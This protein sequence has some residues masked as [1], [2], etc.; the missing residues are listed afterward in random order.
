MLY[1][2]FHVDYLN[3][4]SGLKS[5]S[6]KALHICSV[7]LKDIEAQ[8]SLTFYVVVF[9]FYLCLRVGDISSSYATLES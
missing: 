7:C 4:R 2:K 1:V 8:C 5:V 9:F 6:M 3:R